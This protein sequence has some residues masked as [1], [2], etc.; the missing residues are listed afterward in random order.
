MQRLLIIG[1]G[2]TALRAVPHLRDRYRFYALTRSRDRMP[3]LRSHGVVPIAG[4]L[5]EP[6][7]LAALA[8]IAHGV[9]RGTPPPN[10]GTRDTRTGHLI[11]A[12]AKGKSLPQHLI[13]I[14]LCM[15]IAN[16]NSWTKRSSEVPHRTGAAGRITAAACGDEGNRQS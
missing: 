13:C 5:D 4:D 10:R 9:L 7:S 2:D 15:A 11:A 14:S 8:G 12:L 1:C 3:M 16:A 6:A